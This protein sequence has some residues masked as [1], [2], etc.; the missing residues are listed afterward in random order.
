MLRKNK[1][2][3]LII[4]AICIL[5]PTASILAR[6]AYNEARNFYLASKNFYFNSD[7]LDITM[8]NHQLDNWSGAESYTITF[9]MNS[10]KNNKLYANS[11]ITYD[12]T[13]NCSSNI[14]CEA[15]KDNGIIYASKHTDS[16]DI[17]ITPNTVLKDGDTVSLE[18]YANATSPYTKTLRGKF[19]FK[20]G[21]MGLTYEIEDEKNRPYLEV[22]ITNTLDFYVVKEAFDDYVVNERIDIDTYLGLSE[23]KKNKCS[24]AII[25]LGF[26]PNVLVLDMTSPAYLKAISTDEETINNYNYINKLSFKMDALSSESV[27]IYK[28]NV[29]EDYTYPLVNNN[30]VVIFSYE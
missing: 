24:S 3:F 18:V 4:I 5:I 26:D 27:K 21:K 14:D 20:V 7:K 25:T 17:T 10:Y 22:N 29:S 1:K 12:I 28:R 19:S 6:Y 13:Y 9:N 30:P 2:K 8:V 16:F 11:D 15:T 23:D